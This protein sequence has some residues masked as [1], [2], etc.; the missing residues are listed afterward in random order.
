[1][2]SKPEEVIIFSAHYDHVG[3]NTSESKDKIRNGANDN[4]SGTA[5]LI[6]LAEYFG[7]KA[8]NERTIIFCAFSGEELGLFGSSS[9]SQQILPEK[10][11]AVINIEM[12]GIPQYGI[13]RVFVT[14][15]NYSD[16]RRLLS[17]SLIA[18]GVKI[19]RE[20]AEEI[21]LFRRSDNFPFAQLG[22]PAHT[23]MS[24]DDNEDCYHQPCDEV[25]RVNMKHML[26]IIKG[27]GLAA[28]P[29][30]DGAITPKRIKAK[31]ER[32]L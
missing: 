15:E 24:S 29:M 11:V 12:I 31:F 17:K 16:M 2:R 32:E 22:I 7:W 3:L 10:I 27:I 1:G 8:D 18:N 21:G 9:F 5:A 25:S 30:I 19:T 23:I 14:G 4:A 6:A 20:P 13:G 26:R 28:Q